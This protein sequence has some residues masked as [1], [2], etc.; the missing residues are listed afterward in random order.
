MRSGAK[1][2][3]SS[4]EMYFLITDKN[5]IDKES[6]YVATVDIKALDP[7]LFPNKTNPVTNVKCRES[8]SPISQSVN[9]D[10]F[11]QLYNLGFGAL[12]IYIIF[13]LMQKH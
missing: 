3:A 2:S 4:H 12:L 13:R 11:L 8:F 5:N 10:G 6:K 1:V 7:C 9:N